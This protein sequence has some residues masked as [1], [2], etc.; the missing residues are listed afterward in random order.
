MQILYIYNSE[1][2]RSYEAVEGERVAL[3][4]M[5]FGVLRGKGV[6]QINDSQRLNE[7]ARESAED[8]SDFIYGQNRRF[9]NGGLLLDDRLSLYFITDL[10]CKRTEQFPTFSDYCNARLIAEYLKRQRVDKIVIDGCRSPLIEA[11]RSVS[12]ETLCVVENEL[13]IPRR[14]SLALIKNAVFSLKVMVGAV[15]RRMFVG[16]KVTKEEGISKLFLT[17]YPLHLDAKLNED[18]Y[19]DLVGEGDSYLVNLFTD[20]FH[21]RMGV[22]RYLQATKGLVES[23]RVEILDDYLTPL[24][25]LKSFF[26]SLSLAR[27]LRPLYRESQ[28]LNG[29]D[30]TADL[31]N[32]LF[33]TLMRIPRLLMWEG[34]VKRFLANHRIES[35]YFYLHEYGYGRLFT[36]LFSRYSPETRLVGFQHG[37]ASERKMVYMAAKGELML[38]GDAINNFP[39]PN[40]VLAEDEHSA[41]IYRGA[42]YVEVSVMEK[43]YRLAYLQGIDRSEPDPD[44]VLIAPG[45]HDGEFLLS[46]IAGKIEDNRD[47]KFVLN[48]HPRADNRYI[49]AFMYMENLHLAEHPLTILLSKASKV[50]ATYSSVATEARLLGIEVELVDIPGRINESPLLDAKFEEALAKMRD[51]IRVDAT[52]D[53]LIAA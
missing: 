47:K 52:G 41:A 38:E 12:S 7:I 30:L 33:F 44:M 27:K 36:Y 28:V 8:F 13:V 53:G 9:I 35:L 49:E 6:E 26:F 40:E 11:I 17:R 10:A 1:N 43:I 16:R 32:E 5:G 23:D 45:L 4:C 31:N 39:V 18:K 3:Y 37:P 20:N 24:D 51:N 34:A 42:G 29:I 46:S 14:V 15:A 22:R 50:I 21:Q 19:G 25:A 2:D 48:P